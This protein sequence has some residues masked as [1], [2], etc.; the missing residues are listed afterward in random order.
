MT[1]RF[2]G[3][4]IHITYF[5]GYIRIFIRDKNY[6]YKKKR[7]DLVH[8]GTSDPLFYKIENYNSVY[9]KNWNKNYVVANYLFHQRAKNQVQMFCSLGYT[10][11][12]NV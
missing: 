5:Y 7:G 8:M 1:F 9:Q 4:V 11:M 3:V 10:K 12:T 6:I 2:F